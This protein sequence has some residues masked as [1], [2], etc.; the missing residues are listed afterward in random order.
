[1]LTVNGDTVRMYA[2]VTHINTVLYSLGED[3]QHVH[4]TRC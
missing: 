1:M 2:L 4:E 3:I